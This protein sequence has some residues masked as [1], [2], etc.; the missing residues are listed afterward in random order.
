MT[1]RS[2]A[3]GARRRRPLSAAVLA[4]A[5]ALALAA[6]EQQPVGSFRNA[7]YVPGGE[8]PLQTV[9]F[10]PGSPALR[11]GEA[12]RL[13]TFLGGQ[14]LTSRDDILIYVG[15]SN[16]RVLDARRRGAVQASLPR[17]PA[18]VRLVSSLST[19]GSDLSI[20]AAQVQV[21]RYNVIVVECPGNPAGPDELTT[22]LPDIGCSNA[23]NR[24]TMAAEK[25][26]LI[27]PGRLSGSDGT[28]AAAA[29]QRYE[30]DKVKVVPLESTTSGN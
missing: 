27:A 2:P 19:L 23:Y 4:M 17:T 11:S 28:T 8:L 7:E 30:Q 18:R 12:S 9:Y 26:D 20:D 5:S 22:P 10:Q 6:C 29:V 24:A 13:Q 16:S 1:T 3:P 25:R 14:Y 21:V 15:R